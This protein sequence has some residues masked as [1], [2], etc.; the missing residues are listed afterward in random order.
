MK[1]LTTDYSSLGNVGT[2]RIDTDRRVRFEEYR[3]RTG[4][5][6]L[7]SIISSMVSDP[8]W[9]PDFHGLIDFS[10]AE[11]VL[12]SNDVL[13]LALT[14][15]H[16]NFRSNGWLAYVAPNSLTYGIVRMLG[17]WSRNTGRVQV[18]Q[19][20]SEAEAWLERNMDQVPPGF[21]NEDV[22]AATEFRNVG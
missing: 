14:L 12:S 1:F 6:D 21:L 2:Y 7:K 4:L 19:S 9:S 22:P 20:R 10:E 16:E 13:R 8:C 5:G 15:R 11:L 18:F 17:Y 3:G